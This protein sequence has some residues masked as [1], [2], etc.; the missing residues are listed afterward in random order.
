MIDMDM[1]CPYLV[2]LHRDLASAMGR[3]AVAV[4]RHIEVEM[5]GNTESSGANS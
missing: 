4:I 3:L 2:G 1:L 5:S